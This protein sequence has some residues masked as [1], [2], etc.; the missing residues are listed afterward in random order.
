MTKMNRKI[1]RIVLVVLTACILLGVGLFLSV[2][3]RSWPETPVDYDDPESLW[4]LAERTEQYIIRA[5]PD[6]G[7]PV[8]KEALKTLEDIALLNV[9]YDE[10]AR[11]IH[12][13]FPEESF[14][15]DDVKD[16]L[17][18]AEA[19]DAEAQ[20]LIGCFYSEKNRVRS[21][22]AALERGLCVI[23]SNAL[24]AKWFRKAALQDHA[25][26]QYILAPLVD[27]LSY[28]NT[29]EPTTRRLIQNQKE[30]DEWFAEAGAN[31]EPEAL[32]HGYGPKE[33]FATEEQSREA[34]LAFF[35]E[36]A[37][38]GDVEAMLTI[39]TTTWHSDP[40]ESAEMYRRA[41]ELGS[42]TGMLLYSDKLEKSARAQDEMDSPEAEAA[43]MWRQNAFD[44]AMEHL[45]EGS[46]EDLNG[47]FP[48]HILT[49]DLE[50]LTHGESRE[51]F[52][53]R[54]MPRLWELIEHGDYEFAPALIHSLE[55][56]FRYSSGVAGL[57]P[58]TLSRRLAELGFFSKQA[59]YAVILLGSAVP[60]EQAEGVR[61]LRK[62]AGFG[63]S[64]AQE[65][66]GERCW[67]GAGVPQDRAE[68]MKWMRMA[69]EQR[70]CY[71][72]NLLSLYL[73]QSGDYFEA[74]EW[75]CAAKAASRDHDSL[76]EYWYDSTVETIHDLLLRAKYLLDDF[77][78]WLFT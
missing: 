60:E 8:R 29:S 63:Y 70:S 54:I 41:A 47:I 52:V 24:A 75:S 28:K 19:G 6:K 43:K 39:G 38:H 14:W 33:K 45:N 17:K 55:R 49:T 36:A 68:G 66:L 11:L 35:R 72:M 30:R 3:A 10:K 56:E 1:L 9:S 59:D 58:D 42:I 13:R 74:L 57:D 21:S 27:V 20:F 5:N 50:E 15:T 48:Y 4:K 73:L 67:H 76:L 12:E 65:Q 2:T 16:V 69:A 22:G 44:I 7:S 46:A 37:E 25:R 31:G 23:K 32:L 26:A 18:R 34:G 61:L 64:Y 62:L 40:A 77:T 53:N 71:A 51:D 78:M